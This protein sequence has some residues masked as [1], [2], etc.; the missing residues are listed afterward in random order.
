M[1]LE[2]YVCMCVC[3]CVNFMHPVIVIFFRI[4][5]SFSV[6]RFIHKLCALL[7]QQTTP[8]GEKVSMLTHTYHHQPDEN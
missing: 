2:N 8:G 5:I 1:Q 3:E 6:T 7:K 4:Y